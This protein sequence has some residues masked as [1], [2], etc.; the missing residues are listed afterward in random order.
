MIAWMGGDERAIRHLFLV[1]F[2]VVM[3][4]LCMTFFLIKEMKRSRGGVDAV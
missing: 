3:I 2:G 1:A 4:G